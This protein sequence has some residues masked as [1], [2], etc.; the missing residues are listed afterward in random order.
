ML[1]FSQ[2]TFSEKKEEVAVYSAG[3]KPRIFLLLSVVALVVAIIDDILFAFFKLPKNFMLYVW[4]GLN[5]LLIAGIIVLFVLSKK[6]TRELR[7]NGMDT[8][9]TKASCSISLLS[10]LFVFSITV[11]FVVRAINPNFLATIL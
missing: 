4:L 7:I 10:C 3:Q 8:Q 9:K 11:F 5:V 2:Y 1:D 6:L